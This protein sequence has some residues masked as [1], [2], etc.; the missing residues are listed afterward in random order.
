MTE[1]NVPRD[2]RNLFALL[3]AQGLNP[4]MCDTPIPF[5]DRH[6]PC[7][8]PQ[9]AYLPKNFN[10]ESSGMLMEVRLLQYQKARS[11]MLVTLSGMVMAVRP[12]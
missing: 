12:S 4:R 11:P 3:E 1:Q 9:K 5:Y 2:L 7:G 6:V 10:F 8:K